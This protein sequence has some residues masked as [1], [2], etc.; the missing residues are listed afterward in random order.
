MMLSRVLASICRATEMYKK[1]R[2]MNLEDHTC[3]IYQ[4]SPVCEMLVHDMRSTL[5]GSFLKLIKR[6]EFVG[7]RLWQ[8]G[9]LMH[10][11]DERFLDF[12]F[13]KYDFSYQ[14][15]ITILIDSRLLS[16]RKTNSLNTCIRKDRY[17]Y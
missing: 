1:N 13:L 15:P 16:V 9:C 5:H 11:I 4:F 12:N 10:A 17:Q 14:Q 6:S 2:K 8:I 3:L 7:H